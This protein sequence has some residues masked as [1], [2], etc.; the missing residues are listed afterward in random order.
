MCYHSNINVM[1]KGSLIRQ[2]NLL[3]LKDTIIIAL[4]VVCSKRSQEITWIDPVHQ[5]L[6]LTM[7]IFCLI[8]HSKYHNTVSSGSME[9]NRIEKVQLSLLFVLFLFLISKKSIWIR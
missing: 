7:P 3:F 6:F 9:K 5:V 2:D 8:L 4:R 1:R